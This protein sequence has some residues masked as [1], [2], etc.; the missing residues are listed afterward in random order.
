MRNAARAMAPVTSS[1]RKKIAIAALH[2]GTEARIGPLRAAP[3]FW[4]PM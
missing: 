4:M 1:P 2:N 3:I